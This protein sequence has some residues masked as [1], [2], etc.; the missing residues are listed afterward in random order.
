MNITRSWCTFLRYDPSN[1]HILP[2]MVIYTKSSNRSKTK[3]IHLLL[4]ASIDQRSC[5]LKIT[6]IYLK[7]IVINLHKLMFSINGYY[8][9]VWKIP[10]NQWN[11]SQNLFQILT[12]NFLCALYVVYGNLKFYSKCP[13]CVNY[14]EVAVK[15]VKMSKIT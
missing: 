15:N 7:T 8:S 5:T 10:K 9:Y 6:L 11:I 1:L 3:T 12:W 13:K 2:N 4:I 14:R